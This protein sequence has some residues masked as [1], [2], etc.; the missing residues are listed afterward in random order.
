LNGADGSSGTSGTSGTSL[1]V[2]GTNNRV[3]KFTST[4]TIGDST[5]TDN[6][7]SVSISTN[8]QLPAGSVG[9]PALNAGANSSDT[10][11]GIYF[12]AADSLSISTGGVERFNIN[13]SGVP[14]FTYN[15]NTFQG[16][17]IRNLSNTS[18]ALNGLTIYDASNSPM[19]QFNYIN[20]GFANP[21]LADTVLFSCVGDRKLGFV[22]NSNGSAGANSNMYFQCGSTT[23]GRLLE[24]VGQTG[25]VGIGMGATSPTGARLRIRSGST[26]GT[27]LLIENSGLTT[28][29]Q[30]QDAG[31]IQIGAGSVSVPSL[32]AGLNSSDTNTG[33]Y[34]PAADT[35]GFVEGGVEVMRVDSTST[36]QFI[37]GTVSAPVINAGLN[38]SDTNTGIYF[39]AADSIG[40]STNGTLRMTVNNSGVGIG[41]TP[42]QTFQVDR[43]GIRIQVDA[44]GTGI[45]IA[46]SA[47]VHLNSDPS[48]S[49]WIRFD[50]A[51]VAAVPPLN[52]GTPS[53]AI[54]TNGNSNNYLMDPDVWMEVILDSAGKGGAVVLIPCYLPEI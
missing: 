5:I 3:V 45:N 20:S 6:G 28:I 33:I 22:A 27:S 40:F 18:N 1:S 19:G 35:I 9:T 43:S 46:P 31:Q 52:G 34:F 29:F 11:T 8:L 39:P 42:T 54:G 14:T 36:V 32:S 16:I 17:N 2:S 30:V 15:D 44:T 23:A 10:N 25:V 26:T 47:W 51:R 37:A 48:N 21:V 12:P 7:S 50:A 49:K 38:S 13:S 4:S 53:A 41:M 24:I